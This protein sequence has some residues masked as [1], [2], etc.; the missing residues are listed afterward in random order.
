MENPSN[1]AFAVTVFYPRK[2]FQEFLAGNFTF[3][4]QHVQCLKEHV[5]SVLS[6]GRHEIVWEMNVSSVAHT[7]CGLQKKHSSPIH[8]S[9]RSLT[10]LQLLVLDDNS[11]EHGML[12][13]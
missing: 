12:L 13:C 1:I 11:K 6:C 9:L 10:N 2:T 7:M 5:M 8:I 3:L 4:P